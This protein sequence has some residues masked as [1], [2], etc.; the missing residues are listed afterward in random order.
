MTGVVFMETLRRHWRQA[1]YWGLAIGFLLF[2]NIVAI[3]TVDALEQM[4][5]LLETLPPVM[6]QMFG[7]SDTAYLATPEG[8]LASQTFA[9]LLL[10][11]GAYAILGGL[12]VT[13]NDEER[14]VMDSVLALPISRTRLILEK[15]LAYVLMALL[16]LLTLFLLTWLALILT[17]ALVVDVGKVAAATLNAI[18][19]TLVVLAFTVLM[20]AVI[21]RRGLALGLS[22]L[23][24]IVSYFVDNLG[25]AAGGSFLET[26]RPLSFHVYYD[27]INAMRDGLNGGNIVLLLLVAV[28][29]V[30][31]SLVAY[32]RRDVGI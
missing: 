24:L 18:P 21:R 9:L 17:P 32:Q 29:L 23:F 5:E 6:L 1:I 25:K 20:G 2:V 10:I 4:G 16:V 27:G 3:P 8:Y 11:L 22:A 7:M 15:L 14:G 30:A 12:N 19:G 26:I 28:I 13:A 31:L